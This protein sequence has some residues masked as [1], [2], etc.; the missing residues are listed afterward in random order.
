MSRSLETEVRLQVEAWLRWLPKWHPGSGLSR[1]R[2]CRKCTGSPIIRVA[3]LAD[4]APHSVQHALVMR[5]TTIINNEVDRYIE[6]N[7]PLMHQELQF[8]E[9]RKKQLPYRPTEGLDPEYEGLELDPPPLPGEPYLFT[10][11]ELASDLAST[12]P[13]AAR[14]GS[15]SPE[16]KQALRTELALSDQFSRDVG[17]R[18]CQMLAEHRG[19]ITQAVH[20][21]VEPQISALLDELTQELSFPPS[22]ST[23]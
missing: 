14:P 2:I 7:L 15:L 11:S 18:I 22:S 13:M 4:E 20:E 19:R 5:I 1:A 3:G 17:N 21:F 12:V 6:Q 10:L 8:D 16:M 9:L 23:N